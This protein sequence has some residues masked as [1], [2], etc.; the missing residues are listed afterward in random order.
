MYDQCAS[1]DV[2]EDCNLLAL[3][4]LEAAS[5]GKGAFAKSYV[6]TPCLFVLKE[7]QP[8]RKLQLKMADGVASSFTQ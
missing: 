6:I 8:I 1:K 4:M 2:I 3:L 7:Q 5:P